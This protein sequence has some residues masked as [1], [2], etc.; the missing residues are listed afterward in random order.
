MSALATFLSTH[1]AVDSEW[2]LT[3]MGG[4]DRGKYFVDDDEYDTFLTLVNQHIFGRP[5]RA[6]SLLERH[7]EKGPVLVDLDLRYETGGPLI[8][9]FDSSHIRTFISEYVAAMVYFSKVE[10]LTHDL[11]FY[12]LEKPSPET[13]KSNHKDGV[14][15]QCPSLTTT[16]KYQYGI[17]GFMLTNNT[18]GRVFEGTGVTN[19]HE[20]VFDESVIHRNNWFLYGACKPDKPQYKVVKIW[21]FAIADIREALDG[22]D[23]TNYTE[24]VEIMHEIMTEESAPTDTL[25]VMK[26]LSIRRN[27]DAASQLDIRSIRA[28]EWEELMI[29]WGTGKKRPDRAPRNTIEHT[30]DAARK[31]PVPTADEDHVLVVTDGEDGCRVTSA[32]TQEEIALAYRL[33]RECVNAERR[34][35]DYQDWIN[36]AICLKN[37][38]NTEESFKVWCEITRRVEPSHK[39]A[40]YSDSELRA[41]WNLVRVDSSRKLGMASLQYWSKEDNPEKHRSILSE[42][43]TEWIMNFSKNTHVNVASFVCRLYKHEFRC[44]IGQKKGS[45]EWY[46]YGT[47]AHYW[48]H[49]RTPTE[50]RARLSAQ[51]VSEYWEAEKKVG[52]RYHTCKEE[53]KPRYD[54]KKKTISKIQRD[55]EMTSFKDNVL[56]E[57]QEKFYDDEFISRLNTNPYT[58]GLGNGVLDLRH[59]DNEAMTGRPRVVFREGRPDDYISF[60]MGSSDPDLEPIHWT[61]YNPEDPVQKEIAA[62]FERIYPDPVLREYVLTLLASCLEGANKE[63]KFYVM[64]GVGSNGKSMIEKL[65]EWT[66]GDYGTSLGTQ[67]F[68]RKRPDSGNA[69]ADIITVKCRRYIH[70]GEPDDNEKINTSIM[71]Q[72]SGGDAVQARGLFSDQEKFSIMGKIFMSCNDLPPVS[73]MDNGTWRRIR[74][75]PHIS[76]FKDPGDASIDPSQ[77]IYEKD[78][79]LENKLR[80]W[81]TAFLS[82][83]VHYYDTRYLAHGLKEPDCVCTASNKY[84]EDNDQFQ[85]FFNE[86]FVRDPAAAPVQAKEVRIIFRDWKR[87]QGK[88]C[89]LKEPAIMERMKVACGSGSTEKEFYGIR[90]AEDAEDLSGA[91]TS[92]MLS[93]V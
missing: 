37:I 93:H 36:V 4:W 51:V 19:P 22:G 61:P 2:N 14:H 52:D 44:S 86:C 81:R 25:E 15:I 64:Q 41:K 35:S 73:K 54:E 57:C 8:R 1:R 42:T 76:V 32:T 7:R 28:A 58:V 31:T 10:A 63:Q 3:G 12:H 23:P 80:H 20:D 69:N 29:A 55:L 38:A 78:L 71:K 34:A 6:S 30:D 43:H 87:S 47:G 74:V 46:Q 82:F 88:M 50:L 13:D 70:M 68:T 59:Y 17:R 26:T 27:H 24:L 18:V 65:M 75:I 45:Y 92:K 67:V 9:R 40:H 33:C 62:F 84:K 85:M 60:Q 53:D 11:I 21:R 66:F 5:P 39:K 49:M 90:V 79:D 16:P 83:L 77:H 89:D 56:R 48:K 72:Y 91:F